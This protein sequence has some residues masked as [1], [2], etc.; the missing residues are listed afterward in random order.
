MWHKVMWHAPLIF[1][2]IFQLRNIIWHEMM[3]RIKINDLVFLNYF[4]IV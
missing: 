2:N 1:R 4:L 3:Q